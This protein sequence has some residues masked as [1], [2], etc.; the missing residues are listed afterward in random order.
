PRGR[1]DH[2]D[3][4]ADRQ[5]A[6]S[7]A[8]ARGDPYPAGQRAPQRITELVSLRVLNA[9]CAWRSAMKALVFGVEPEPV[10]E[11]DTDN[12]LLS[13]LGHTPMRLMDVDDPAFLLPDWVVCAPRL[14][15]ICGSDS[16]QVFMDWGEVDADNPMIDFTSFPHILGHEVVA[17]V[18][19]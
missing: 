1:R 16:K 12:P 19:A 13:M 11:P 2:P 3:R 9:R 17:D 6:R 10:K 5:R 14:T 8:R 7:R 18:V 4:V 15:G